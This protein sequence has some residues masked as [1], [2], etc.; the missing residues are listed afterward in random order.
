VREDIFFMPC[1]IFSLAVSVKAGLRV[2]RTASF[3]NNVLEVNKKIIYSRVT[4]NS[5]HNNPFTLNSKHNK[6]IS[7]GKMRYQ[8]LTCDIFI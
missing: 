7:D 8:P 3:N 5:T 2:S 1:A 6:A 4:T